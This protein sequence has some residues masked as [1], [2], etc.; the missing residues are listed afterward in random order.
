MYNLGYHYQEQGLYGHAKAWYRRAATLGD[1][2]AALNL[3]ILCDTTGEPDEAIDWYQR[4]AA[5]GEPKAMY[6]LGMLHARRAQARNHPPD[7]VEA[8]RWLTRAAELADTDAV[9]R[10]IELY[11]YRGDTTTADHWRRRLEQAG[12]TAEAGPPVG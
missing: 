5:D 11:T 8:E 1:T 6:N 3:G 4:A 7:L 10:L 9:Q 2:S 12:G